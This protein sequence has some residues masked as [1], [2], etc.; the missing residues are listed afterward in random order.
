[1]EKHVLEIPYLMLNVKFLFSKIGIKYKLFH[2][3]IQ[4]LGLDQFKTDTYYPNQF[5]CLYQYSFKD[6]KFGQ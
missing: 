6:P 1:M 2:K 5:I 4:V 3:Y